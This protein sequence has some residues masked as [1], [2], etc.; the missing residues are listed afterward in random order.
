VEILII[1]IIVGVAFLWKV[2]SNTIE[3]NKPTDSI[4]VSNSEIKT[5]FVKPTGQPAWVYKKPIIKSLPIKGTFYEI[6]EDQSYAGNFLGLL[7]AIITLMIII[8]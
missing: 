7:S 1:L 3:F 8:Q 6:G 4:L 2:I 5:I